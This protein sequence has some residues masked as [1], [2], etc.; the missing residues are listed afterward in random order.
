MWVL[1]SWI[2]AKLRIHAQ[3]VSLAVWN[4]GGLPSM[5]WAHSPQLMLFLCWLYCTSKCLLSPQI[6]CFLLPC[7]GKKPQQTETC[8]R[9]VRDCSSAGPVMLGVLVSVGTYHQNSGKATWG[10]IMGILSRS[11]SLMSS[12]LQW[13]FDMV[14]LVTEE[15]ALL[16]DVFCLFTLCE[17]S[18]C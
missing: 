3:R 7:L 9:S 4:C 17:L 1:I 6:Q 12:S 2:K 16:W 10:H 18:G 5:C 8:S 13:S 14:F 11:W 15:C